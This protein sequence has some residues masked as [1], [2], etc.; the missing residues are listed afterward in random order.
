VNPY[1]AEN[2]VSIYHGDALEVLAALELQD[3]DAFVTDP[4]YCSGA[5]QEAARK[6]VKGQ[7]LRRENIRDRWGWFGG[8]NMSTAALVWIMRAV[9]VEALECLAPGG[10]LCAFT[11]WRMIPSLVPAMESSGMKWQNLAVWDKG[12]AGLGTGFRAQ[13]EIVLHFVSGTGR[14]NSQSYGNV[15]RCSRMGNE[16]EHP[17]Q[18]P[19]DL[20][21]Q[22]LEVVTF[23][24]GLVVDPFAG[25]GTTGAVAARLGRRAV[26]IEAE[27]QHCE[28]A[29]RRVSHGPLFVGS[30]GTAGLFAAEEVAGG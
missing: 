2:G 4:P 25:S 5:F 9:A 17:T 24:G 12:S 19:A 18:K 6:S 14:Y 13:H 16:K 29:A 27:E 21:Q 7:G 15:L 26:L 23:P 20:I 8:D 1:H 30:S 11:D 22:I 10:S 3:V 28:T